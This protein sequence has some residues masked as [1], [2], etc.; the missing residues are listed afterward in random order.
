M[1]KYKFKLHAIEKHKKMIEKDRKSHLSQE[2]IKMRGIEKNLLIIK[3]N[4]SKFSSVY[5]KLGDGS[6]NIHLNKIFVIDN[7]INAQKVKRKEIQEMILQ[8]ES[9]LKKSFE[10]YIDA[11]KDKRII[12]MLR[13]KDYKKY[14]KNLRKNERKE[15]DDIYTTRSFQKN[16]ENH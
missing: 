3:N 14:K 12:E 16:K 5:E 6:E 8:Q 10:G 1:K 13:E 9:V 2:I 11:R 4:E 7:F 15:L